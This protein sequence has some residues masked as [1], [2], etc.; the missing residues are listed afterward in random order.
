MTSS[1][2][3]IVVGLDERKSNTLFWP[4]PAEDMLFMES[5]VEIQRLQIQ[6]LQGKIV[7]QETLS[8]RRTSLSTKEWPAG[9]YIISAETKSGWSQYKMIKS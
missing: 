7:F 9:V 8:G 5:S 2:E 1:V 6:T 3:I 4:N